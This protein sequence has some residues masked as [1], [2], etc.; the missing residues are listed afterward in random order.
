[1][2]NDWFIENH[3]LVY[4]V[5]G[6]VFFILG[7]TVLLQ[8]RSYSRLRL[9]RN[10]P[11][12]GWFGILHGL[13]EWGDIFIPIQLGNMGEHYFRLFDLISHLL[14]AGSFW[15]LF[16]FGIELM[17]P[18][19]KAWRWIRL[20]PSLVLVAW[21]LGPM[22]LGYVFSS[23][24]AQWH[25]FAY[26]MTRY[27][28]CFPGSIL[29]GIGLLRQIKLQIRPLKLPKIERKLRVAAIALFAYAVLAGLVPPKSYFFP[30]SVIN[31]DWFTATFIAPP[32]VFRSFVGLVL[33]WAILHALNVFNIETDRMIR[34]MEQEQVL[35]GERERIARDIHDGA[36]QQVYA[37]G[38][39]AQSLQKK[40]KGTGTAETTQLISSID[41]AVEQL[42]AF[43]PQP[44]AV[45]TSFDL[46]GALAPVIEEAQ[47]NITINT[48]WD[49]RKIPTLPAEQT[50]HVKAFLTEALSNVIRHS[51]S[52]TADIRIYCKKSHLMIEVEDFG[53]GIADEAEPGY[54]LKNMR[55][56]V[57]LLG[58]KLSIESVAGKG[59]LVRLDLPMEMK[60]DAHPRNDR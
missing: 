3:T 34:A 58:A 57:R 48:H 50:S 38:L 4:F 41:Q 51:R 14:L 12:L 36:L 43:L 26:A 17:R 37:A 30:A 45:P 15:C 27:M 60:N 25:S 56:R 2:A 28:L 8:T 59:T 20:I 55:D 42:R 13:Y 5:Y 49:T 24:L 23:D 19:S 11:W 22:I 7:V 1:M 32:P 29:A 47:R 18:A 39:L 9:A 35:A 44:G 46:A 40:L 6:L 53:V 31:A 21:A 54:G 33:L 10:L 52:D 16:Q